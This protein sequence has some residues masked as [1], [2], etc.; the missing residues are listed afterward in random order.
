MVVISNDEGSPGSKKPPRVIVGDVA[1]D[2]LT[3]DDAVQ[4]VADSL[5][6]RTTPSPLLIVASNAQVVTLAAADLRLMQAL[7]S[8]Q[9]V[10]PDGI[11][12]V[13]AS[14]L[15]GCPTPERV[16]GGEL[17]ERL[18][19]EFSRRDLSVFFL[20][21]LPAAADGAARQLISRYPGLRIAGCYCPQVGFEDEPAEAAMVRSLIAKAAPDLLCVALGVP[22]QEIWMQENCLTLPIGAAIGV[23]AALDTT[24]GLRKRA[25]RWTQQI[26]MEWLYRLI[27]EPRRL[28]RR[29]LIGNA[30]FVVLI[31]LQLAR[32]WTASHRATRE[33]H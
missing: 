18:C 27:R 4:W 19:A 7:R 22:K 16:P 13:L 6:K 28:W 15:L 25:P 8:A 12:V 26:G 33:Q 2:R 17:M 1:V 5:R 21:G 32:Q 30:Q 3:M 29:Y 20:G 11:S 24:A 14:R 10:V 31:A 9:L 23:G